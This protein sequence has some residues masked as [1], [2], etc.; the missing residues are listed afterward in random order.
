MDWLQGNIG[1]LF[2]AI[3]AL[4]QGAV[5][6]LSAVLMWPAALVMVVV[7]AALG[8]WLRGWKFGL[9]SVIGFAVIDG[10]DRTLKAPWARAS[11]CTPSA[12]AA[13]G[14]PFLHWARSRR[15]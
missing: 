5:D 11:S 1:P 14:R 12:A 8:W 6:G 15:T 10:L 9:G 7:F 3:D 4:A 13:S 2:D